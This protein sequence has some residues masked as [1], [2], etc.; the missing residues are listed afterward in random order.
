[1]SPVYLSRALCSGSFV[2]FEASPAN[3][4]MEFAV[5]CG[6]AG[7]FALLIRA[8]LKVIPSFVL[9]E[10]GRKSHLVH[11]QSERNITEK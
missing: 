7:S 6:R 9:Q 10:R 1:M 4:V 8:A 3:R 2:T 11:T 5:S